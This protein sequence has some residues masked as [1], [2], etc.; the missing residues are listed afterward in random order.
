MAPAVFKCLQ[1]WQKTANKMTFDAKDAERVDLL[2]NK[3][4]LWNCGPNKLKK[5]DLY[6]DF[7]NQN[8]V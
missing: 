6:K 8:S 5:G 3:P 1:T 7:S 4:N 2:K